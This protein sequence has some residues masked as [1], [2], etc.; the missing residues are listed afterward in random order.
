LVAQSF[1]SAL[2]LPGNLPGPRPGTEVAILLWVESD[3][4]NLSGQMADLE[5]ALVK[6]GFTVPQ[7][8]VMRQNSSQA[9]FSDPRGNGIWVGSTI[10]GQR[11]RYLRT[12]HKTVRPWESDRNEITGLRLRLRPFPSNTA[13]AYTGP[14]TLNIKGYALM[15]RVSGRGPLDANGLVNVQNEWTFLAAEFRLETLSARRPEVTLP[16]R[17]TRAR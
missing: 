12:L 2:S 1:S 8:V 13:A 11:F 3:N 4:F 16:I 6:N 5:A 17:Y 7:T 10:S 15:Q 9:M 14:S